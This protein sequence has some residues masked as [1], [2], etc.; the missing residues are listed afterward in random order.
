METYYAE[1]YVWVQLTMV[2]IE[3]LSLV[4]VELLQEEDIVNAAIVEPLSLV[5]MACFQKFWFN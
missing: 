5:E 3:V 2:I 4:T 1:N